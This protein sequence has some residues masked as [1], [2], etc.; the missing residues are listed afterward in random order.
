MK[1]KLRHMARIL[2]IGV[3]AAS[4]YLILESMHIALGDGKIFVVAISIWIMLVYIILILM[5][6]LPNNGDKEGCD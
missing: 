4:L 1:S 5:A 2:G 3:I 6:K